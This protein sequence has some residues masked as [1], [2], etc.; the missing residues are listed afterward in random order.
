M[1]YDFIDEETGQIKYFSKDFRVNKRNNLYIN[2]L[3]GLS[4]TI[5]LCKA[6]LA[7]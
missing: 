7:S 3:E 6:M 2:D 5:V 4:H 1:G